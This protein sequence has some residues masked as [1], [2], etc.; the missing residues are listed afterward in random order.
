MSKKKKKEENDWVNDSDIQ[1]FLEMADKQG[2][3]SEE[4]D[5][6]YTIGGLTADKD[7]DFMKFQNKIDKKDE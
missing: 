3:W 2:P 6:T 7:N 4:D 1:A 5:K